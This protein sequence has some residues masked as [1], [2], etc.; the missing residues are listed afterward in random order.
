MTN[1]QIKQDIIAALFNRN[2]YTKQVNETEYRT[3]CPYCGDSQKNFHT[4]HMYIKI[5]TEDNFPIVW[6]CFKC[7]EHGILTSETLAMLEINDVDLRSEVTSMNKTSDKASAYKFLNNIKTI[8]FDYE[9][10]EIKRGSKTK[11]IE[12]RLG[13]YLND[14]D[15]HKMKVI[16]SFREFLIRNQIKELMCDNPMAFRIEDHFV[17]F[18]SY[19]NSHILF[20]DITGKDNFRWIKYPI[21]QESKECRLFYSMETTVDLFTEETITINLAEG[22]L[23]I[24]SAYSNLG[25]DK[26]NTMNIAVCGKRYDTVINYLTSMG[27]VGDNICLNVFADNDADFN[28]G[29]NN[30]PMTVNYFKKM[31]KKYKHL[32]GETNIYFNEISKDIGVPRDQISLQKYKL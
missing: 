30:V 19:G 18:L 31:M 14:E 24:L 12:D 25:Y 32:Y 6:N 3:R 2:T 1:K 4:G 10:P 23:D 13:L 27:F 28:K 21:T 15:L 20:R 11:Y 16:T 9:L 29:K 7:N 17:G 26:E 22:V 5:N 8:I